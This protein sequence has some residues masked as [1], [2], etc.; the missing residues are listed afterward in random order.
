[1]NTVLTVFK[2]EMLDTLRDKRTLITAI[3]MPAFLIP[4][5][6]WGMGAVTKMVMEKEQ[7]KKLTIA[8]M[9]APAEFVALIDTAKFT[10]KQ[11]YDMATGR[12]EI[13]SDSLD[14]M[15]G[16]G[17][18]FSKKQA[19]MGQSKVDFW[20]KSTNLTVESRL[21]DIVEKYEESLLDDR[22]AQLNI[23]ERTIDPI[24]LRQHDIAPPK[25]QFGKTVGGF[26][27]YLF[28]IFCFT[29]CMYPALD[30]ITGE[31]ERGTIETLLTVPASRFKILGGKVLAIA[32]VGLAA[33]I[34]G[35]IGLVVA[36]RFLP[37]M[38]EELSGMLVSM[39]TPKFILMLFIM[40]VPLCFFFA[41][42]LCALV[43]RAK[44]FKEAQSIVSPFMMVVIIP[45]AMAMMPGIELDWKT[46]FVPILN[47]ALAT[48]EIVAGTIQMPHYIAI[49]VSLVIV[50]LIAMVTSYKAFSKEGMVIK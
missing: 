35:I 29:G 5:L 32:L 28:I 18:K 40:L 6:M 4:V 2:K 15:I 14:A 45:A 7:N 47:I 25:E 34:M 43:V 31:K 38:P 17:E 50:A 46:A 49:V 8:L 44:S 3:I 11:G 22:I 36:A 30:L 23:S 24:L 21:S 42:G 48:K 16:F 39:V 9:N 37:D 19:D 13:L 1:M 26:L 27:P 12:D 33:A 10:V 41:G 20:Y